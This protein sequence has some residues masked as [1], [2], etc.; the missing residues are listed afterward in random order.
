M[1]KKKFRRFDGFVI[2]PRE[3]MN[4]DSPDDVDSQSFFFGK[5]ME[6]AFE[7][8]IVKSEG[9]LCSICDKFYF[10]PEE[11]EDCYDECKDDEKLKSKQTTDKGGD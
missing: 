9:F 7:N 1:K 2:T 11:A 5:T 10:E 8:I 3:V 4:D 6:D